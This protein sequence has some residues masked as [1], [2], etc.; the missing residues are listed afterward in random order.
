M[1]RFRDVTMGDFFDG[2]ARY[3]PFILTLLGIL[4]LGVVLPGARSVTRD[5]P[6]STQVGASQGTDG[7]G[8]S[9]AG[10]AV[11]EIGADGAPI[12][13][14]GSDSLAGSGSGGSA[15]GRPAGRTSG[16]SA[17][18]GVQRLGDASSAADCIKATGRIVLPSVYAVNCVPLVPKGF[19]NGGATWKGVTGNTIKIALYEAQGNPAVDAILEAGGA[20]DETSV[21]EDDANRN[22]LIEAYEHH[23]ETYG[24]HVVWE[25]VVATGP[26]DDDAAA[27]ADAIKVAQEVKAFASFGAPTGTNAYIDEL[28]ARGVLCIGCA[29]SQPVENYMKWKTV[30]ADLMASTQGY[31]HRAQ[32]VNRINGKPAKWAGDP[33]YKTKTRTFGLVFYDTPDHSYALGADFMEKHLWEKYRIKLAAKIAVC[34]AHID[35]SC[36]Q[37]EA[38]AVTTKLKDLGVTTV[39]PATDPLYP[40]FLTQ[41]ATR[42]AYNPEWMITGATLQDTTFFARL[43]DPSQWRNAFG[44]S[45]LTARIDTAVTDVEKDLTEWHFGAALTSRPQVLGFNILYAGTHLAGPKLTP[46]TFREGMFSFKPTSGKITHFATSMGTGLWPWP[47]YVWADDATEI[48]WDPSSQGTSEEGTD[49][50]GMYRYVNGGKRYL[51]GKWPSTEPVVF[52][53]E[54]TVT[55]YDKRP[56]GDEIPQ[57]AHTHVRNPPPFYDKK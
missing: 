17:S 49:G 2:V 15:S 50:A 32:Y 41:E 6:G 28:A 39:L 10:D 9:A 44:I 24:R 54:G 8:D 1:N 21:E 18:A 53:Q 27:K 46:D 3:R 34:G 48:W 47:D 13:D 29:L 35:P 12:G 36:A 30:Y 5:E 57:P 45:Y 4:F 38:R 43:Y 16:G 55:I 19:A 42:Q 25:K 22:K 37:E 20:T 14:A 56:P 26:E 7:A 31:I 52:T 11:G 23:Y 51:P 33:T 40:I